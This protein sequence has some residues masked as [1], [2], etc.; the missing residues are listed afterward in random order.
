MTFGFMALRQYLGL[1]KPHLI[2]IM[3]TWGHVTVGVLVSVEC[4]R[5]G[6]CGMDALMN[7]LVDHNMMH[8]IIGFQAAVSSCRYDRSSIN[9]D[10]YVIQFEVCL[11]NIL[12]RL[13]AAR[14]MQIMVP[15]KLSSNEQMQIPDI[16]LSAMWLC[17]GFAPFEH[18]LPRPRPCFTAYIRPART[19]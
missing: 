15:V 10:R 14:G 19:P 7:R 4:Y 9:G 16:S 2:I 17:F 3:G 5:R 12:S 11:C 8:Y 18:S 1:M 6:I 13:T